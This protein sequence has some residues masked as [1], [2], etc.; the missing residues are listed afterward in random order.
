VVGLNVDDATTALQAKNFNVA[1]KLQADDKRPAG[2]VIATDP[3]G[4]NTA[5]QGDTITIIVSTGNRSSTC[6]TRRTRT[7]RQLNPIF[8]LRASS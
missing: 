1:Q 2:I 4:G 6:R 3:L 7:R 5:R 8:G